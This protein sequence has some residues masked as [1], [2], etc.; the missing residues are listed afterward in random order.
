[1]RPACKL[2]RTT[3]VWHICGLPDSV[4]QT[5][6][7]NALRPIPP[8]PNL[9]KST[10]GAPQKI[11]KQ[12]LCIAEKAAHERSPSQQTWNIR[13]RSFGDKKFLRRLLIFNKIENH[14]NHLFYT[15]LDIKT[16]NDY[17]FT[18]YE[19]LTKLHIKPVKLQQTENWELDE[20]ST[21]ATVL[22]TAW[23]NAT[24]W[25]KSVLQSD[26][27]NLQFQRANSRSDVYY[28]FDRVARV[29]HEGVRFHNSNIA[30]G[31]TDP[32]FEFCPGWHKVREPGNRVPR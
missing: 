19:K 6:T 2:F 25:T 18:S 7:R 17:C 15:L 30:K 9:K 5:S 28:S 13:R 14:E 21:V 31:T 8:F 12:L 3:A 27:A 10:S 16:Y 23:I 29:G 20:N 1:M 11:K 22:P 26:E 4:L 24:P 32:R